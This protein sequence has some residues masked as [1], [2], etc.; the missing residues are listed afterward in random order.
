[1][2]DGN[3]SRVFDHQRQQDRV[4]DPWFCIFSFF[5][6]EFDFKCWVK[7]NR[8]EA[9]KTTADFPQLGSILREELSTEMDKGE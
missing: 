3:G 7:K 2:P 8:E 4:R 5:V 9:F 6:G 1:M